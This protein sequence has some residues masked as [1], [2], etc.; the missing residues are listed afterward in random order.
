[1]INIAK[2]WSSPFMF[3]EETSTPTISPGLVQETPGMNSCNSSN[4]TLLS[5]ACPKTPKW[6]PGWSKFLLHERVFLSDKNWDIYGYLRVS[7]GHS[8]KHQSIYH[9]NSGII[10]DHLN[11]GAIRPDQ[12]RKAARSRR[13]GSQGSRPE[14]IPVAGSSLELDAGSPQPHAARESLEKNADQPV[15]RCQTEEL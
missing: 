8:P 2:Y 3:Y 10:H 5:I 9:L 14:D 15:R 6:L 4:L 11:L 13:Q 1:M 12:C 7:S